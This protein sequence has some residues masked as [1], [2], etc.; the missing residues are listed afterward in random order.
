M[1]QE[2]KILFTITVTDPKEIV[3]VTTSRA[4]PDKMKIKKIKLKTGKNEFKIKTPKL[5]KSLKYDF[6]DMKINE[7]TNEKLQIH[8]VFGIERPEKI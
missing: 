1:I 5:Q 8:Y 7:V 3:I 6:I 2:P 4:N